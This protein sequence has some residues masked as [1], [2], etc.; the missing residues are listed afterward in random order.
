MKKV[1]LVLFPTFITRIL[2]LFGYFD[3]SLV[4]Q[5]RFINSVSE[6]KILPE[7]QWILAHL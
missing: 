7:N 3:F 2:Y 5:P 1:T 6:K 4:T